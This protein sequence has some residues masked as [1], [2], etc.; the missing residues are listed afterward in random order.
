MSESAPAAR[1]RNSSSRSTPIASANPRS[2]SSP[3]PI[4]RSG[5]PPPLRS[6]HVD[7]PHSGAQRQILSDSALPPGTVVRCSES[8]HPAGRKH[9]DRN[10][11]EQAGALRHAGLELRR[12]GERREQPGG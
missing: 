11:Q 9:K 2:P 4:S 8:G 12:G 3:N 7:R 10:D 1:A 5:I 6:V